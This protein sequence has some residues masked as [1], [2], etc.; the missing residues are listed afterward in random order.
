MVLADAHPLILLRA[1]H[2]GYKATAGPAATP[3][4]QAC[5]ALAGLLRLSGRYAEIVG[6]YEEVV[7]SCSRTQARVAGRA[8]ACTRDEHLES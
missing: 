1:A 2:R 8:G 4:L 5:T 3:T 7:A 6:V